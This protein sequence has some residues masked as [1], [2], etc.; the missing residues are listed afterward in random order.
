MKGWL[1]TVAV[2]WFA[3]GCGSRTELRDANVSDPTD[4]PEPELPRA[5][6]LD[7]PTSADD[8]RL[9]R[10]GV[11][12]ELVIDSAD[13]LEVR[14]DAWHWS[15]VADGCDEILPAPRYDIG[16]D[17]E[18]ELSLRPARPGAH[19]VRLE[20]TTDDGA[21]DSCEFEV[22]VLGRGLRVELCWDTSTQTDLDLYLHRPND[23][24]AWYRPGSTRPDE[25]AFD[26][27]T[28]NPANCGADLRLG[29]GR[30]DWGYADSPTEWCDPFTT[31]TGFLVQGICP[32]PRASTDNNQV[33]ATGTAEVIQ[34]DTPSPGER[35]RIM[36][37]NFDNGPATPHVYVYC[38][39]ASAYLPPPGSPPNFQAPG[40]AGIQARFGTMW[41]PADVEIYADASGVTTG[42]QVE[43]L[44][45]GEAPY[46]TI[47]DPRY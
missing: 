11:G 19:R 46:V 29:L 25:L 42:C 18:P 24:S 20:V 12:D 38:G 35:F 4:V 33:L 8:P 39:S 7:C 44:L 22:T 14:P 45:L 32:N 31:D 26:D 21:I 40:G 6:V 43:P 5:D 36:V 37:Q 23:E 9:P 3:W 41:R 30:V 10:G 27:T 13:F 16:V 2:L 17:N 15:V 34:L 28:C 1:G 47:D